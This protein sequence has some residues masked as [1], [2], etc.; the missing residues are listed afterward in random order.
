MSLLPLAN[1]HVPGQIVFPAYPLCTHRTL[2][3]LRASMT[4]EFRGCGKGHMTAGIRALVLL[5][6]ASLVLSV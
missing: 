5:V 2:R 1:S 6:V 4:S 3:A